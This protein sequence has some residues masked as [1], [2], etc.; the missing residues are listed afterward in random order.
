[1]EIK[2]KLTGKNRENEIF[3]FFRGGVMQVNVHFTTKQRTKQ[4]T[5]Y[6]ATNI[7]TLFNVT[8]ISYILMISNFY[9]SL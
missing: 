9:M 6:V 1:M 3:Q 7:Q 8:N 2:K 5:L 4:L